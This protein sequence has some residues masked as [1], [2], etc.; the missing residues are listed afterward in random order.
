MTLHD[1]RHRHT[2]TVLASAALGAML[3]ISCTG[4][5]MDTVN[6][7][8]PK[9]G[10]GPSTGFTPPTGGNAGNNPL[11]PPPSGNAATCKTTEF[12]PVR[13]WR[14]SDD[15]YATA[16]K[17][18][19]PGVTVP[20]ILTPG[21]SA[22]QFIDF[23]EL[24]EI[25]SA[26][27]SSVRQSVNAVASE[28]VKSLD[29]LLACKSGEN[30]GAC[31]DRFI[32]GFASR[33]FRRPLEAREKEGLKAVYTEGAKVSPAEGTRMVISAVLQS[34]SFLYRTEL[35]KAGAVTP[36]Q[37]VELTLHELAST[38]SFLMLDS[39]PDA[40]LR[41]SA[42]DGS[43]AK[44]DVFKGHVERLLKS[45]RVQDHLTGVYLKWMGLGLG[46]NSDLAT[47][48]KEFTPE[49]K[50]SL[51]QETR[52]FFK[53]LLAGGG[54]VTDVLTS[55]KGFVDRVLATHLGMSGMASGTNFTPVTYP[56]NERAGALTLPGV[57]ARYSLGHPEVFRGKFVRDEF[58]CHEIP[59]PP[60]IPAIEEE[61][62]AAENLPPRQQA[63]RRLKNDTCGACHL[64]MDPIG[65]SFSGY[66]ALGRFKTTDA[67]GVI[68]TSGELTGT[69]DADGPVK[70]AVELGQ[71]LAK[72]S[73]VRGCMESKMLG[74]ALGR[75]TGDIDSCE[76]A[77]IDSFVSTGG[78]KLSDLMAA[79]VYSSAFR[80]RT[81]GN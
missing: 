73:K 19:L 24:F 51:E 2:S 67:N 33:A 12:T 52:L 29:T 56:A 48:E 40:E 59:P 7:D 31:A 77:K 79:V 20:S 55:R 50:A 25:G 1:T 44:P 62:K 27:S 43:L 3:T 22:Q 39:I 34:G 23:A 13:V 36:G 66:D 45:Q 28:A 78:G 63:E 81:G 47:V 38:L 8:D 9:Q 57:I 75:L 72:S 17:D 64:M 14:L 80:F 37:T 4:N 16:V 46:L 26:V 49:L 69:G 32:E 10:P 11:L 18:L 15:Q 54:T 42:D 35:G 6:S 65:L 76:L 60:D 70:N 21:R 71:K 61:T 30:A 53:D 68:D 5:I 41:A 74:Y 58:L